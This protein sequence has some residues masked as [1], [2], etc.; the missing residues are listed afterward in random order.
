[1]AAAELRGVV[2][3]EEVG[4]EMVGLDPGQGVSVGGE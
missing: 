3:T 4:G 1:V 2:R